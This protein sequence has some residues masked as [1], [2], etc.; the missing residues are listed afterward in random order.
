MH[1]DLHF[2]KGNFA[3]RGEAIGWTR[4]FSSF[5]QIQ[6]SRKDLSWSTFLPTSVSWQEPVTLVLRWACSSSMKA[7]GFTTSD[8][9][10]PPLPTFA[11]WA[12]HVVA[13]REKVATDELTGGRLKRLLPVLNPFRTCL[14][15]K[16]EVAAGRSGHEPSWTTTT[17]RFATW[18][19]RFFASLLKGHLFSGI[20]GSSR[21]SFLF[22]L[23]SYLKIS[24]QKCSSCSA[25]SRGWW[26]DARVENWIRPREVPRVASCCRLNDHPI[27]TSNF[28]QDRRLLL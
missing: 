17:T 18:L 20:T 1:F 26:V 12:E 3:R 6:L 28:V 2:T 11:A 14:R 21:S 10:P 13:N 5:S 4:T 24:F 25:R 8:T 22:C 23:F 19:N 27:I 7:D 9:W 15:E 16:S